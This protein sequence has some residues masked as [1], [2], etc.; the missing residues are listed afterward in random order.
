L[1]RQ[2]DVPYPWATSQEEKCVLTGLECRESKLAGRQFLTLQLQCAADSG[3]RQSFKWFSSGSGQVE[4]DSTF[5]Y[6]PH[7]FVLSHTSLWF[8]QAE[9]PGD[10]YA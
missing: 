2:I 3:S 10:F 6:L 8:S 4:M 5:G 7:S 1:I 9:T